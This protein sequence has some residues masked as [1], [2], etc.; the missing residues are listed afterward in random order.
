MTKK[1]FLLTG[2]LCSALLLG[3]CSSLTNSNDETGKEKEQKADK[4]TEEEMIEDKYFVSVQDYTGEEYTLDNGDETDK[5]AEENRDEVEKAIKKYFKDEYKTEVKVH[6]ITG[7]AGGAS[8]S[9]ES[10]GQPHFYSYAIIPIDK[11]TREI[12]TSG[13]WSQEGQ[14]ETAI[15]SGLYAWINEDKFNKLDQ[16][17]EEKVK[18]YPIVGINEEANQNGVGNYHTTPYYKVVIYG[19]VVE[20]KLLQAYMDNPD[21]SKEEWANMLE[22]EKVDPSMVAVLTQLY[23]EDPNV[24]PSKEIFDEIVNDLSEMEELAAGQYGFIL[25]DNTIDK[26][27]GQNVKDNSLEQTYP[28]EIIKE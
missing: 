23:M 15:I 3:G 12:D 14:V 2:I 1:R 20:E 9:V 11:K 10:I 24:E 16:Y 25:H 19:G 17:I 13:V 22:G 6:N 28:D 26:Y 18:E 7:A 21:R 8:V 27:S 5:I 4:K